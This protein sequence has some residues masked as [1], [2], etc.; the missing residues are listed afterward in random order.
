M[1]YALHHSP[2]HFTP[3]YGLS[4]A[5]QHRESSSGASDGFHVTFRRARYARRAGHHTHDVPQTHRASKVAQRAPGIWPTAFAVLFVANLVSP[6]AGAIPRRNLVSDANADHS[7]LSQRASGPAFAPQIEASE[8]GT[9]T[10]DDV[11]IRLVDRTYIK[12]AYTLLDLLRIVAASRSPFEEFGA[13]LGEAYEVFADESVAPETRKSVT[14][15][16]KVLDLS[17]SLIP[18]VRLSR[19]PGDIS[20]VAAQQIEGKPTVG[21]DMVMLMR[22]LDPRAWQG[23]PQ[24]EVV[25][26]RVAASDAETLHTPIQPKPRA[27]QGPVQVIRRPAPSEMHAL[28]VDGLGHEADTLPAAP[29]EASA[30]P[31][32]PGGS[33]QVAAGGHSDDVPM[34]GQAP[35]VVAVP[36]PR[37]NS[38][39]RD[40]LRSPASV[41]RRKGRTR[42]C[43]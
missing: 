10:P 15:G 3:H 8:N 28:D 7:F 6:A 19:V 14:R 21:D 32:V 36:L 11:D 35:D 4:P 30:S 20:Y 17:T 27:G 22:V 43:G 37:P 9:S 40:L 25:V 2:R 12:T 5:R 38:H 29:F 23:D 18:Q 13:S 16:G 34:R 1:P 41:V 42:P 26:P 33:L 39:R 31:D 24:T